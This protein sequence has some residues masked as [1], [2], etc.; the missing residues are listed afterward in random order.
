MLVTLCLFTQRRK[1]IKVIEPLSTILISI[2][3][4]GHREEK[5][6]SE[7]SKYTSV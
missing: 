7:S 3:Q 5:D 2:A 6:S 1:T 4:G